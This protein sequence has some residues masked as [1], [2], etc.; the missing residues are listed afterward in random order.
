ML[1]RSRAITFKG[2]KFTILYI[3]FTISKVKCFSSFYLGGKGTPFLL[4]GTK[5]NEVLVDWKMNLS[6]QG[7]QNKKKK[8]L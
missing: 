8:K 2:M 6:K 3:L 7:G 1:P 4:P 5:K